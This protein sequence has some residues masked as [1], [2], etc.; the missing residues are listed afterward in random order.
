MGHCLFTNNA[1]ALLSVAL[2]VGSTSLVVNSGQGSLF[3]APG[4]GDWFFVTVTD[5]TNTEI[6]RCNARVGDTLTVVRGQEGTLPTAFAAGAKVAERITAAAL[7]G[8]LQQGDVGIGAGQVAAGNDP[9]FFMPGDIKMTSVPIASIPAGWLLANGAAIPRATYAALFAAIGTTHGAG[10][11]VTTFNLPNLVD[12]FIVG[13]GS[14]YAMAAQGGVTIATITVAAHQLT[15]AEMPWHGHGVN[16]PGHGHALH[17]PGHAHGVSDPG[18][19]HDVND[20]G[21]SHTLNSVVDNLGPFATGHAYVGTPANTL[22]INNGQTFGAGTGIYLNPALAGISI[23]GAGTGMWLDGAYAG[24]TIQGS[25]GDG[26]HAH[27][28]S[29]NTNLPPYYALAYLVKT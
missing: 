28:A 18:H 13:A 3:P 8:Y 27:A 15:V 20:P 7:N 12:K 21:H 22:Q 17:D 1:T 29:Q 11:G 14:A 26:A 24:I 6:V 19:S 16:D 23:Q 25:G 9:R 4:A 5:G 2:A 10:D